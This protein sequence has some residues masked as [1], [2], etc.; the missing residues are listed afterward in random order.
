MDA[1]HTKL[2]GLETT[3]TV[4]VEQ[5]RNEVKASESMAALL[6]L[7][8][9]QCPAETWLLNLAALDSFGT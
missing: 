8:G 4:L 1:L 7:S 3:F 2:Q 6:K 5:A 9:L